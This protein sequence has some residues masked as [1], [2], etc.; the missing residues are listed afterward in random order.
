MRRLSLIAAT[1]MATVLA[2]LILACDDPVSRV[3]TTPIAPGVAGVTIIGPDTVAPGKSAQFT[4]M[5]R[6]S[7]GTTK[8]HSAGTVVQWTSSSL[9]EVNSSGVAFAGQQLGDASLT[10]RVGTGN[11]SRQATK[12]IVIV[13]DGTFRV[14]GS[15]TEAGYPTVPVIAAR[16]EASPGSA[17]AITDVDGRYRLYGVPANATLTVT[18]SGYT[19]SA[20]SLQLTAHATWNFQLA[21]IG[22]RFDHSG[23]YTLTLDAT[24]NCV[25]SR[26]PEPSLQ[27]RTYDATLTQNGPEVTVT[28]TEPRFRTEAGG[29]NRFTGRASGDSV[30]FYLAYFYSYYY[31]YYPSIAERLADSSV[32]VPSGTA[33]TT[34][35]A[36]GLS[37]TMNGG[38]QVWD[39][40]FPSFNS[41][42]LSFCNST[43]IQ[44]SLTPR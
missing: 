33:L 8:A 31:Y 5:I 34:R 9:L 40:R 30:S 18:K 42:L 10:A 37:G 41:N 3:P 11:T 23:L 6:L 28:L 25:S 43:A 39:S 14:V 16:V 19:T 44:F 7:D 4:A 17:V 20:Q 29:G 12:Q 35:S 2:G 13:P 21:L 24:G 1:L 22:P 15:V 32:L 27:R 36:A 26:P 38:F